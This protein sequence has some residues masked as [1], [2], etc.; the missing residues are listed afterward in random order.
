MNTRRKEHAWT[1]VA[2]VCAL[3]YCWYVIDHINECARETNA[4]FNQLKQVDNKKTVLTK[5]IYWYGD[6]THNLDFRA[7]SKT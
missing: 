3:G 6:E 5:T 4:K 7:V 1:C 2:L